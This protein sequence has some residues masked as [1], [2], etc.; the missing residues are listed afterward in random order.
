MANVCEDCLFR[1]GSYKWD[2]QTYCNKIGCKVEDE[3]PA[4][5]HFLEDSH[6]CCYDC[7]Y[8][9]DLAVVHKC[10]YH[11][12]TIKNPGCWYCNFFSY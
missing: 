9:K 5:G 8:L 7:S 11:N 2:D 6:N 12:K 3:Q 10:T 4:C 1:G